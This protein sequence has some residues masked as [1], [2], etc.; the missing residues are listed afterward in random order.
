MNRALA[1]VTQGPLDRFG[2]L[3]AF[4]G[5]VCASS[6]RCTSSLGHPSLN[7][8]RRVIR[9]WTGGRAPARLL[10]SAACSRMEAGSPAASSR[11]VRSRL[12]GSARCAYRVHM[13][14]SRMAP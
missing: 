1:H 3:C 4:S 10:K 14:R 13:R 6:R 9:P 7:P 11:S 2:G 12:A 8:P 5:P